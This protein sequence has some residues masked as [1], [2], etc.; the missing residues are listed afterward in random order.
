MTYDEFVEVVK[1]EVPDAQ[2]SLQPG[3]NAPASA[4]AAQLHP[5]A[6]AQNRS[7]AA[8]RLEAVG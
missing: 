7:R 4:A 6:F 1:T 3:R 2:V 8:V 5:F